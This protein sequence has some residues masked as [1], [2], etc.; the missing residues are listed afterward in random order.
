LFMSSVS[1]AV[2]AIPEGLP[3]VVTVA[4]ALGV[5]RMVRRAV[6]VRR[7]SAVETLGCLQVIC[8][9]KTGT[10]T[11]GEMTARQLVTASDVY[12]IHGEGYNLSGG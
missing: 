7:L 3:A 11:V 10:L 4:L 12:S 1:L 5:Q 8:T 2:A 9:D 6:L